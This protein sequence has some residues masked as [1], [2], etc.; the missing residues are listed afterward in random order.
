[1]FEKHGIRS[2]FFVPGEVA[3]EHP[4]AARRILDHGHEIA[5][6]GLEHQKNEFLA[7]RNKQT[8]A[9]EEVERIFQE[10]IHV[11][12][13]GFRAPCLRANTDTLSVLEEHGYVYDSSVVPSFVPGYYGSFGS[14]HAPY[15]PSIDSLRRKGASKLLEI[16]VSVNPLLPLSLSAAWMRNLG[17][18]WVKLGVRTNFFF[19]N[20]VVF[21]VHPRDVIRLPAVEGVPWHLYVNVGTSMIEMLEELITYAKKLDATFLRA[22]D[23]AQML[24]RSR[25]RLVELSTQGS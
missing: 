23:L 6:H 10:Q 12:P 17:S 4:G 21:Y 11:R 7:S 3:Q 20:P 14:P 24:L 19:N 8:L 18:E 2:T 5:C 25:K 1:L 13:V 22:I 16:P 9:I 15:Y